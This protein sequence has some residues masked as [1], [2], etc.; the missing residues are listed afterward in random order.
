MGEHTNNKASGIMRLNHCNYSNTI[1][2]YNFSSIVYT[3]SFIW[4]N[5]S[6]SEIITRLTCH[7]QFINYERHYKQTQI[8]FMFWQLFWSSRF[9]Q[10]SW[11]SKKRVCRLTLVLC[12]IAVCYDRGTLFVCSNIWYVL[13]VSMIKLL[14]NVSWYVTI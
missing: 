12:N 1:S 4:I 8:W 7:K 3:F 9:P 14:P 5:T 6:L 11:T 13:V 2:A 10:N